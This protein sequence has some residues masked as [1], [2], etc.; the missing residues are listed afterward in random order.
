[1]P[2]DIPVGNGRML[3]TFDHQY[4]IRDVYF[5]HVGQENHAGAGPCRFGVYTDVPGKHKNQLSWS[6]DP[7]WTIRQR[8][9][10][11]TLTTSV[12]LDHREL[13]LA[14]YCNDVVD[15]HRNILVRKIKI[16]NL[17]SHER[18]VRIMHHQDFNMFGTKIG[19]T[20]YFDPD[21]RSIVHYRAKRYLM[22][23]FFSSGEQRIDEYATGTSGFHGAEGT[24]RDAEDGHL[25][26]NAI[27]QGA[28]DSTMSHHVHVPAEGERTIYMV[29]VAGHSRE[30][31]L[32]LHKWL[33][34][35]SPQ[36]VIDRTTS[37]WRLWVGGTNFN[38]GNLPPKVV[39]LFKRSLLIIRT[40]TDNNGAI[41]AANDSDIMQFSRDTYSYM[42][43]RDGALVANAYDLAGFSDLARWFYSFCKDAIT[44]EGYFHHKY[45]P[46]G[47]PASSWHPWV[48]K[49]QRVMPIQEDETA[50]V[51]WA[52][53]RHYYRYRDIEFVRPLWV[54]LVQKAA[55]FMV[56][57]RDPK[58]GLPL[59]SY[60]LWEERWGVHAFTVATVYGGLKAAR[61][62]AVCFGDRDKAETYNK[63]AEE[64]KAAAAKHLY[65]EKLNR[66][67][68]R[69]VPRDNPIAPDDPN[70][71]SS[72]AN[73]QSNN[74]EGV[75][76]TGQSTIGNG[77]SA[78]TEDL[79][80]VDE[81]IDASLYAIFKFHLFEADDPRVV[82]TMKAVESKLWVK[83]RVGGLARYENDYYHR[84][85]NDIASV[86]G[87]PWFI[88][89]LWLADYFITQAKTP[90]E[91]KMALPIFEWA[92]SHALES[93]VLAE[94]VNPY[95]NEPISVSPL[96]WSHAT[97]ISTVIKYIEKL[98]QLQRCTTCRQPVFRMRRPGPTE[99][100]AQAHFDRLEAEFEPSDAREMASAVGTFTTHDTR[101][102]QTRRTTLAIDVRD[103]I[104]CEVCVAHCD[105][106]VLK[107]VDG[108]ALIDLRHLNKCDMDG[109]C[110]E[111]CPT[112]V[113]TLVSQVVEDEPK[114]HHA[115]DH[116]I[117][118]LEEES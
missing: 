45:N 104:G 26:G 82:S 2:R 65:N 24:W 47:S 83:T 62:F 32:E 103:C 52:L 115:H 86:P 10:R 90:A 69:L 63:A 88:C 7:G 35:H 11:D 67:V 80:E 61:N 9:L 112:D 1:M 96:T 54:D 37:Y 111:V 40:Q 75:H 49:G 19:D 76:S 110:V 13:K 12:S 14:M 6:S 73:C 17:T 89:T 39:E 20:A 66:F 25:Q 59:P 41:V 87:N 107:M 117:A 27:A 101:T 100:K 92:A 36:G 93:G 3:V 85:S 108:K 51:V 118:G 50:L 38:F 43:P 46:D 91:L 44:D 60:D 94:Q 114:H 72:V 29:L 28:V 74:G 109:H 95:T 31:L 98:E 57:Y 33:V 68:R 64:I 30:E 15:F 79:F 81:V 8:Y 34:K 113:V 16:K 21:L 77:Q 48:L 5:P 58:T 18:Q 70:Y 56:S 4:Q 42:W 55:D 116:A 23:T 99:V 53:W 84:I 97:V 78:K 22:M 105:K 71:R 102:P 106:G